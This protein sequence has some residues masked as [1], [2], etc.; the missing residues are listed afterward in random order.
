MWISSTSGV[1]PNADGTPPKIKEAISAKTKASARGEQIRAET[2]FG[3]WNG[4]WRIRT[5]GREDPRPFWR[6]I[7]SSN[8]VQMLSHVR[9]SSVKTLSPVSQTGLGFPACAK[10]C[11]TRACLF[12][13]RRPLRLAADRLIQSVGS[14]LMAHIEPF[15]ALRYDP[16]QVALAQVATQPYDKISP[17]MQDRYY[18]ASPYNLVRIILGKRNAND[19]PADNPYTRAAAHFIDWRRQGI[20][21][22][23]SQPSLY[24]YT[25]Q[26]QAPAGKGSLERHGFIGLDKVEDYAAGVVFRH[27]QTLAKTN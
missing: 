10:V 3:F 21:F 16:A 14:W 20:F 5:R 7:K 25:Q 27:E 23:D 22:Q 12:S 2:G 8:R 24:R 1:C 13:F 26:F 6:A 4:T 19:G 18:A 15:R 17:E 9:R 11:P